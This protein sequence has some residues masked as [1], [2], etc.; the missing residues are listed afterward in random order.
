MEKEERG[1]KKNDYNREIEISKKKNEK[2]MKIQRPTEEQRA[3]W[4]AKHRRDEKAFTLMFSLIPPA[5]RDGEFAKWKKLS[6]EER[7]AKLTKFYEE[8]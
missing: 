6:E 7:V 4:E 2:N 3:A 1:G 8:C 5:S